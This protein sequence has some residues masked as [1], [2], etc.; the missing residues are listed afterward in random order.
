MFGATDTIPEA[1]RLILQHYMA[2]MLTHEPIARLG[3]DIE[4]VHKMRVAIRRMRSMYKAL[5]DYLPPQ[6]HDGLP[7]WL[8]HAAAVLGQVRDL[9]V[10]LEWIDQY[11]FTELD[12][13]PESLQPLIEYTRRQHATARANLIA[14]LDGNLYRELVNTLATLL[15]TPTTTDHIQDPR[16]SPLSPK[17][18]QVNHVLP[19]VVYGRY[20]RLR[21]HESRFPL[22]EAE[23]LHRIRIE[24]KRFRY[25]LEAFRP[26]L[27]VSVERVITSIKALQ[28]H[29]G[30]LNDM[31][32]IMA[33]LE[34][35][36]L[37]EHE[38]VQAWHA[39]CL[40][41]QQT[42]VETF[43]NAWYQFTSYT[44]RRD[45]ALAVAVL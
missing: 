3:E 36:E 33:Y 4:G 26:V 31:A 23:K 6:Y 42:L 24:C 22:D 1:G 15:D 32:T 34:S 14:Y 30:D 28:E 40:A 29:L 18:V 35:T 19:N 5:G 27:G 10:F 41:R 8:R 11:I 2:Q 9:D 39:A 13:N 37:M 44:T 20:Q 43:P 7:D 17:T 16:S 25:T 45:L 38:A 12:N 21:R